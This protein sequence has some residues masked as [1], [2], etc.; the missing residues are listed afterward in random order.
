MV[1]FEDE[2]NHAQAAQ[3]GDHE[4]DHH[5]ES[6]WFNMFVAVSSLLH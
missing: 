2:K 6:Y 1:S 4:V 3:A 5:N